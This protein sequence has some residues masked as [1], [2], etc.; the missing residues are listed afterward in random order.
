MLRRSS[1][2]RKHVPY[3]D[4]GP[5]SRVIHGPHALVMALESTRFLPGSSL[6]P[7]HRHCGASGHYT[8]SLSLRNG[9]VTGQSRTDSA[10]C[11]AALAGQG[12]GG[13]DYPAHPCILKILM[14]TKTSPCQG[15]I[16]VPASYAST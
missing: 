3:P 13:E 14:Q 4:T 9:E 7:N 16:G 11:G 5:E 12:A 8:P 6:A 2:R 1:F 10:R 15:T